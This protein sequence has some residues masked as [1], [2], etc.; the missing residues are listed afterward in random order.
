MVRGPPWSRRE[1]IRSFYPPPPQGPGGGQLP[2]ISDA[3]FDAAIRTLISRIGDADREIPARLEK[4]VR[5]PFALLAQA[6]VLGSDV[7]DLNRL[8]GSRSLAQAIASATGGFHQKVLGSMPGWTEQDGLVDLF[9][10]EAQIAAEVK[11][12]HNT[13]NADNT[14]QVIDN[15]SSFMRTRRWGASGRGYLVT[16]L[17]RRPGREP[18]SVGERIERIDGRRFYAIAS[19][20][21]DALDLVFVQLADRIQDHLSPSALDKVDAEAVQFCRDLFDQVHLGR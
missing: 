18:A 4:N 15:I 19:G 16:I 5:D 17:P 7:D 20:V 12:K 6:C 13:T 8:D 14:R 21:D 11:N 3:D 2:F 1:L 10:E 9:N